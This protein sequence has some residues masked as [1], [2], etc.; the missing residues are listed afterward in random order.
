MKTIVTKDDISLAAEIIKKGGLVAVPTETVYGLSANGFN[1][2]AVEK[3]YEVKN[4]PETKPINLLVTGMEDAEKVCEDIPES[5]YILA[6]AFWPGP[7]TMIL[8]KRDSVPSIVSAGLDTLGVR[9]PKNDLTLALIRKS[10]VPLA[11]PSANISGME[12][13]KNLDEVLGYFDGK[14]ECV[15]DGG[16][17]TS[18]VASTIIDLTG[19]V[20]KILRLGELT[21]EIIRDRT[22][23]EVKL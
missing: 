21:P 15:I 11:T 13:G 12:S 5:A 19:P 7:M 14:I 1:A 9:A 20:P 16:Q 23:I 10:G 17:C 3:I 6:Q 2:E 18:G 22:K 4:R 8:K